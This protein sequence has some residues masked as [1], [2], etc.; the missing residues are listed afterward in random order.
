MTSTVIRKCLTAAVALAAV[1]AVALAPVSSAEARPA[2]SPFAGKYSWNSW[3]IT[4]SNAGKIAGSVNG[5]NYKRSISGQVNEDGSYSF[6]VD[7]SYF[8]PGPREHGWHRSTYQSSGH[9][10]FDAD[11][12]IVVTPSA[13][14]SFVWLQ[15]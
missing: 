12:N 13:G 10:A 7:E 9:M 2:G 6:T 5:K 14:G 11:G 3:P 8:E 4:I 1:A 15:Q